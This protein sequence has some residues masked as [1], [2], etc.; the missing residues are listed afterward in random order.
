MKA[1]K[2]K[3]GIEAPDHQEEA[4]PAEGLTGPKAVALLAPANMRSILTHHPVLRRLIVFCIVSGGIV[5]LFTIQLQLIAD[6]SL[7]DALIRTLAR[8][9]PWIALTP[10]VF[11]LT[12]RFPLTQR[13]SLVKHGVVHVLMSVCIALLAQTLFE[14]VIKPVERRFVGDPVRRPPADNRRMQGERPPRPPGGPDHRPPPHGPPRPVDENPPSILLPNIVQQLPRTLP[15]YWALMGVQSVFLFGAQLRQRERQALEL[16]TRLTQSQLETLKLQLQPHFLFNALNAISTLVYSEPKKADHMIGNLS[17]LL[18]GVLDEKNSNEVLLSRELELLNAY[19]GIEQMRFGER[20]QFEQDVATECLSARVPT[21]LLQPIVENAV[22]HGL[23]PLGT[24]G[25]VWLTARKIDDQL[26]VLVEDN[27]VG[28]QSESARGW[29]IGL[30][31]A[32]A[33]L[34][35]LYGKEGFSLKLND[36]E[37]GGTVVTIAFPFQTHPS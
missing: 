17:T 28:R 36:R 24:P 37:G 4:Q 31:N 32:E 5:A 1:R 8:W 18:R 21:L 9:L 30:S 12:M 25:T 11:W 33:R 34:E 23:E 22:R 15:T 27:G 14:T 13:E 10:V 2:S 19:M 3:P 26:E 7:R 16:Q 35:A 6:L 29:G 20:V